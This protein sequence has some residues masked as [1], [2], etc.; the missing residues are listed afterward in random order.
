MPVE[1]SGN[2][3]LLMAAI[4]QMEGNAD[5][6]GLY[7]PQL[8]Q[9]ADY[10]QAK[11]FDPENQLCTDDFAGHLAHNVNLSAKAICGLGAFAK[12]CE[13]R[14][15]ADEAAEHGQLVQ[16][17]RRPLGQGSRRWRPLP[18][19]LRPAGNVEPEVQ[20]DLG[21]RSSTWTFSRPTCCGRSWISTDRVQNPYGLP[22]DNRQ[23][24]TKL[25]WILWTATLTRSG[26]T[27]RRCSTPCSG[28]STRR[29]IASPMTDWYFTRTPSDEGFTARP[30]RRRCVP[31]DALRRAR[32]GPSTPVAIRRR[33]ATGRRC[34]SRLGR[35]RSCPQP[36]TT[37]AAWRYTTEH[38][39][40][41]WAAADFD[42]RAWK[43]GRVD[44]AHRL[45]R[46]PWS[47]RPG[48]SP[49]HLA[50]P[51]GS[52]CPLRSRAVP[53]IRLHHD[54]HAHVFLNGVLVL[55]R[56][57]VLRPT[58]RPKKSPWGPSTPDGNVLAVHCH[59]T[60]GGQ[61]ID[62]GLDAIVPDEPPVK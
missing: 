5:F 1:E 41:N 29:R 17:L 59:Q 22:L 14:G 48:T 54:E 26:P 44:S 53:P 56:P 57:V 46:V 4:A 33:L 36:R 40:N 35:S 7:W 24:Y 47:G 60:T 11:G 16:R 43:R 21:P 12:L 32:R 50:P 30:G 25:D 15:D 58:T 55:S 23:T 20:P 49:R 31:A 8:E 34:P 3:L 38:P 10:L 52:N 13:M 45:R 62:V 51:R 19:G 42:D 9:W 61:Y 2:L 39:A 6:A 27:S 37:P 28:S 18:P